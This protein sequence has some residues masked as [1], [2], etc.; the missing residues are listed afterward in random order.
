MSLVRTMLTHILDQELSLLFQLPHELD[1]F[2]LELSHS[3]LTHIFLSKLNCSLAEILKLRLKMNEFIMEMLSG[4]ASPKIR[5]MCKLIWMN[6]EMRVEIGKCVK[7]IIE[8]ECRDIVV[9]I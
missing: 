3:P 9:I 1:H 8:I 5:D 6:S 4:V 7:T 2:I